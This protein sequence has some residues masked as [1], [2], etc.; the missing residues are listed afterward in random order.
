V[1]LASRLSLALTSVVA[2]TLGLSFATVGLLVVRDETR[3]LDAALRAQAEAASELVLARDPA[4]DALPEGFAQVPEILDPMTRNLAVYD[5][6]GALLLATPRFDLA[7]KRL[8]GL[9]AKVATGQ[10]TDL[11]QGEGALRAVVVPIRG[12]SRQLLYAISRRGV[13][14]DDAFIFRVLAAIYAAA[15]AGTMLVARWLGRRLT[16]DVRTIARAARAVAGGDL[17]ARVGPD[18]RGSTETHALASNLDHM[19]EQL[20]GLVSA[21]RTFIS[22]AAHE[23]RSPLTAIRGEIQLALRRPRENEEYQR[24]LVEMLADVEGLAHLAEDLL[25][26]AR[27]Q[28]GVAPG[29]AVAASEVVSDAAHMA[30]GLADARGVDVELPAPD[31]PAGHTLVVGGGGDAARALRNLIDN[32]ITHSAEGAVVIVS[33][34]EASGRVAFSVSDQGVGVDPQD[35]PSLFEPFYRGLRDSGGEPGGAGLGLAIARNIARACGG[36]LCHDAKFSPG[37]RFVLELPVAGGPGASA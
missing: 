5:A 23:L 35:A 11:G 29:A 17:D 30:R 28:A 2:V 14:A 24:T 22:H 33:L 27:I 6:A 18:V 10:P 4:D 20:A 12:T 26:L 8:S 25:T 9:G 21:Q 7:P 31:D 15:L 36:D 37:A 34:Q 1:K 13:D 3:D 16:A 32:A 19:I